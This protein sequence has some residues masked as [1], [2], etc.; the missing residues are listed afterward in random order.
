[1]GWPGLAPA[2]DLLSCSCKK[3]GKEHAPKSATPSLRYGANLCRGA[4]GVCRRTHCAL[5]ASFRQLRQISLR[6]HARFDAH[7]H[8]ASAPPQAQPQGVNSPTRAIA[9]L[10]L[11]RAQHRIGPS[12]AMARVVGFPS[13]RAEKRRARGGHARRS[14][15]ASLSDFPQ[16]FEDNRGQTPINSE[17]WP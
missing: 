8:P 10:G 5:R 3:G 1:M 6:K 9:A 16:L 13:G 7:A 15:H 11:V 4:C 12:A 2:G 14:A 17:I